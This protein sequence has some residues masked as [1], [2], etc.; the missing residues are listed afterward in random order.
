[1]RNCLESLSPFFNQLRQAWGG[2]GASGLYQPVQ[3]L[4]EVLK[5][6]IVKTVS[7]IQEL[8]TEL[9]N[10]FANRLG[11][12]DYVVH[13]PGERLEISGLHAEPGH[14]RDAQPQ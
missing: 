9:G 1:M 2:P 13:V 4:H 12:R 14:L 8:F 10:L 5:V 11:P 3:L 6:A 7:H